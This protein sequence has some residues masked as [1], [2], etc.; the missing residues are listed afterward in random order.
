[1]TTHEETA[2]HRKAWKLADAFIR[3]A[4]KALIAKDTKDGITRNFKEQ[5]ASIII[6]ANACTPQLWE[7]VAG[8]A[9]IPTPSS[10]TQELA[11]RLV[12]ARCKRAINPE[13]ENP[14]DG[15]PTYN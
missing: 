15:F 9:G 14:F 5:A 6:M 1:M 12:H 13:P 3:Y 7:E 11:V 8:A 2:R 4:R 10:F